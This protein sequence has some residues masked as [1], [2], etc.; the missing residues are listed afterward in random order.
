MQIIH[1]HL[2]CIFSPLDSTKEQRWCLPGR[3]KF[4]LWYPEWNSFQ[5]HPGTIL[6]NNIIMHFYLYQII[7]IKNNSTFWA[8]DYE[9]L[10]IVCS[11]TNLLSNSLKIMKFELK[12]IGSI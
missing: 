8:M 6:K 4:L 11:V 1:I 2:N 5:Q 10:D 7:V 3:W 9:Y 12:L